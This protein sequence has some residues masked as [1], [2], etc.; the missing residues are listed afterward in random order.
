MRTL[1]VGVDLDGVVYDFTN[2][3]K[4]YLIAERGYTAEQLPG[5]CHDDPSATWMFFKDNWGLT[6]DQFLEYCD[7]GTDAGYIFTI[8][9]PF[10]GAVASMN[11]LRKAGHGI[12]I[13]TN[14]S[15]GTRS[16]HNTSDW[17]TKHEVPFDSLIF[18][19]DKR[20]IRP[21]IFIDDYERNFEELWSVGVETWLLDRPWN[22]H[23]ETPY[24]VKDWLAFEQ[25]V[26][27]MADNG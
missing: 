7:A 11:R 1:N 24:R 19:R 2:S 5:G 14:R 20:I 3:L 8:G 17:L 23:I 16:H 12:H 15:F 18:A 26:N 10:P 27:R 4:A 9:D 21:D 6:S 22:R 13:V 25:Q